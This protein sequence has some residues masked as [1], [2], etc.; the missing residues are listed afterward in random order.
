MK[1]ELQEDDLKNI[2]AEVVKQLQPYLTSI[3]G[4]TR[5]LDDDRIMDVA[6]LA[7]Y[8]GRKDKWIYNHISELPHFMLGGFLSFKKSKIDLYIERQ[9]R[10]VAVNQSANISA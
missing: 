1:I 9:S 6:D 10:K 4:V 5:Q 3:A 8:L 2:A 7:K